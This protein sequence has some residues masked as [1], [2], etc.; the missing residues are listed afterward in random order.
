VV[1]CHVVSLLTYYGSGSQD[2]TPSARIVL[3]SHGRRRGTEW[4]GPFLVFARFVN[5][6]LEVL[7]G[8][9]LL[10]FVPYA[11]NAAEPHRQF[12]AIFSRG[13]AGRKKFYVL[14]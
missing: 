3:Q 13:L 11:T 5:W 9:Q 1:F 14:V 2:S 12:W 4:E 8:R 6:P 7:L 10:P